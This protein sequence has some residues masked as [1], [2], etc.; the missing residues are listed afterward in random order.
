MAMQ[1]FKSW[2]LSTGAV[3]LVPRPFQW[4][5]KGCQRVGRSSPRHAFDNCFF[6]D[7]YLRAWGTRLPK[8][9]VLVNKNIIFR[10][11]FLPARSH[12]LLCS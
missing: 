3:S 5:V 4:I 1:E 8:T 7:L 9:T 6:D 2:K 11:A 12:I 10:L